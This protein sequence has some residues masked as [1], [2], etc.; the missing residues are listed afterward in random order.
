MQVG[1]E[2][3]LQPQRNV[4]F[5]AELG[6]GSEHGKSTHAVMESRRLACAQTHEAHAAGCT[7]AVGD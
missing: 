5:F 3:C 1:L 4:H 6:I 7:Q 2:R